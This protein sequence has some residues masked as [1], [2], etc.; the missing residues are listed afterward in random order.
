MVEDRNV[1]LWRDFWSAFRAALPARDGSSA[2]SSAPS[3][4]LAVLALHTYA[5]AAKDTLARRRAADH[6]SH[7]RRAAAA[8]RHPFLRGAGAKAARGRSPTSPR[9]RRSACSPARC[10][11]S[12]RSCSWR[13]CGS[14]HILFYP[15]SILLPVLVNF[16][17]GALVTSFA[18]L[19]AFASAFRTSQ[20]RAPQGANKKT[21]TAVGVSSQ[22][23]GEND[24]TWFNRVSPA[25][26]SRSGPCRRPGRGRR[27]P[28]TG[29]CGT[30]TRPS[31][32]S[33]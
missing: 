32:T 12:P 11:A 4:A 7:R 19:G 16:S 6:R 24:E 27:R 22:D 3:A 5:G 17:L 1:Y 9:R 2:S 21:E 10:P 20:P 13:S 15:A 30:G 31:T 23:G 25:G 8:V 26:S 28:S 14:P 18:V 29:P 33:R